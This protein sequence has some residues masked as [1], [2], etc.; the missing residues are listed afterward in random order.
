MGVV[1]GAIVCRPLGA[2]T[3]VPTFQNNTSLGT[4][5]TWTTT[6]EQVVNQAISDWEGRIQDN[7]TVAITFQFTSVG[8]GSYLAQWNG[9]F[10]VNFGT[11]I[12]PWT[13]GVTHVVDVNTSFMNP[14]ATNQLQFTTGTLSPN[15]WDALSVLR[16]ELGH[17]MGFVTSFYD[18]NFGQAGQYDKWGMHISPTNV[19]D[20]GGLNVQMEAD[21]Q[22]TANSGSTANDLM[23]SQILNGIRRGITTTDLQMLELAYGYDM[24]PGDTNQNGTVNLADLLTLTRNFGQPGGS[25]NTGDFNFDGTT[26][27]TDFLT[28]ARNFGQTIGTYSFPPQILSTAL[29]PGL[30]SGQVQFSESV[31]LMPE[32]QEVPEPAAIGLVVGTV[33][34]LRRRRERAGTLQISN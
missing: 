31:A 10:T 26:N 13:P 20:P 22:H 33:L 18:N 27:L 29:Q 3:I 7:H 6:E 21:N 15:N 17:A 5:G 1:A 25:W 30:A 4:V 34:I 11:N 12:Y 24:V 16:H 32:L 14:S 19:F 9:N 8:T 23:N 2:I 28:L